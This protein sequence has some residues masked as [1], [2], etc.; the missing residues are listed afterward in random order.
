MTGIP[1]Y[2]PELIQSAAKFGE[3]SVTFYKKTRNKTTETFKRTMSSTMR[4][5]KWLS[6]RQK[7]SEGESDFVTR[8]WINVKAAAERDAT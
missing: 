5:S 4:H 3:A 1:K 2:I 7:K 8:V 6:F